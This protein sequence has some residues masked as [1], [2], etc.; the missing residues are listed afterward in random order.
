MIKKIIFAFGSMFVPI[1]CNLDLV[2]SFNMSGSLLQDT[3]PEDPHLGILCFVC[4]VLLSQIGLH[5]HHSQS[6][7][8]GF[9]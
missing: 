2:S 4:I 5:F 9:Y 1:A 8:L 3:N 7:V 6:C